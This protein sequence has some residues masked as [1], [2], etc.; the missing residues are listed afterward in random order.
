MQRTRCPYFRDPVLRVQQAHARRWVLSDRRVHP[1]SRG[2]RHERAVHR[3][4][5]LGYVRR[6]RGARRSRP[7]AR[8]R[9]NDARAPHRRVSYSSGGPSRDRVRPQA[10]RANYARSPPGVA[11]RCALAL[12]QGARPSVLCFRARVGRGRARSADGHTIRD[13]RV[14]LG[15]VATKPWRSREAERELAGKPVTPD[16]PAG[17]G[18]CDAGRAR[19][20]RTTGSRSS[21]QETIVRA[22]LEAGG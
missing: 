5:P 1:G 22:L 14:A 16:V 8:A 11:L 3:G 13:A 4:A 12:R 21:L 6:P 7:H 18:R 10:R 19:R 15:G 2:P 20:R 9:W 17:C